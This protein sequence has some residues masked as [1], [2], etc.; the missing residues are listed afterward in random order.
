MDK[1]VFDKVHKQLKRVPDYVV[2]KLLAWAMSVEM[3]G[4]R[5]VRKIPG[6][7]DEPLKGP[8]Q[9]QRSIRLTK[10]YRAIYEEE[11]DGTVNLVI[12]EEVNHHDY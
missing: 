8:R 6:Y 9:G 3:K 1:V 11:H 12:L 2:D 7:H 5:E 10:S 4:L